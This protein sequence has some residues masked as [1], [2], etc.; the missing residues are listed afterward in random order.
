MEPVP[1]GN[2][3][4]TLQELES[5]QRMKEKRREMEPVW[6]GN[7]ESTLQELESGQRRKEKR[8]E[9]ES[10]RK[11]NEESTWQELESGQRRKKPSVS[12]P[13]ASG[14][15][16]V[17]SPAQLG[18]GT[19]YY[20]IMVQVT[21]T[22]I[23]GGKTNVNFSIATFTT[24]CVFWNPTLR[25]WKHEGCSVGPK[26]TETS[27][28]CLCHHLTF[29]GSTFLVMPRLVDIRDT[30]KLFANA[31]NNPVALI[32]LATLIGV[33]ILAAILAFRKDT[34]DRRKVKV[35]VLADND[36][37]YH[38]RYLVKVFT[39][40]RRGAG[41]TAKVVLTL[42]GAEGQS[43]PHHLT[44][45]GKAVFERGGVDIFL[46]KT[47]FLGELHSIRL[48][49]DN[50]GASPAWYVNRLTVID[51]EAKHKWYF[52]CDSWLA[53]D[54]D[55]GHYDRV[56]PVASHADITSFRYLMFSN[57]VEKLMKDHLWLSVLTRCPWSPFTRVQRLSCCLT[58]LICSMLINLMF[59]NR[60]SGASVPD[61]LV[62]TVT[63]LLISIQT[64][65]ILVP[66]NFIIVYMF[67]LIQVQLKDFKYSPTKISVSFRPDPLPE[68]SAMERLH[69]V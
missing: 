66:A 9:M 4:S 43:D 18:N 2:E 64:T 3:E 8:R 56:F 61:E 25:L 37:A 20:H 21:N 17:L 14:Y 19:G 28:Q 52:L 44:D 53:A 30:A 31:A 26:T 13:S 29:F 33:Y 23:L 54:I 60:S 42:Y 46:L 41:T 47:S 51:L 69:Q 10:V 59:W 67:H 62:L 6:K 68:V 27:T 63:Q 58:L 45:P 5:G 36:A 65:V 39:G 7:E 12:L 49:H 32:L 57:S 50:L 15:T 35:T 38:S 34:E 16:W 40:Y 48:W 1:K 55:D 24:Q 22:S 11:G